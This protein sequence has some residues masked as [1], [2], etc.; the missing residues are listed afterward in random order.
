MLTSRLVA[1]SSG[2]TRVTN[3]G[4][5]LLTLSLPVISEC[6][7]LSDQTTVVRC[8]S[9]V[10]LGNRAR[11]LYGLPLGICQAGQVGLS[12]VNS[13]DVCTGDRRL[14]VDCLLVNCNSR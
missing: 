4:E 3:C 13:A 11:R 7:K 8:R 6:L 12:V 2:S 9:L 14:P 1:N 10:V 5:Q